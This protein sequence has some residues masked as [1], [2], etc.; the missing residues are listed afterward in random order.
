[1]IK[2]LQELG[3]WPLYTAAAVLAVLV[4]ARLLAVRRR[5]QRTVLR[6]VERL[7]R[8]TADREAIESQDQAP[9]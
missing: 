8:E 3:A 5:R 9:L 4:L 6:E 7:R 1:M 2:T